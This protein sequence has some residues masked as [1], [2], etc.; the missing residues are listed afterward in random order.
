MLASVTLSPAVRS[1]QRGSLFVPRYCNVQA[2]RGIA[3]LTVVIGH[4][5]SLSLIHVPSWLAVC[6]YSGVDLFFAISGFIIC[7]TLRPP[8]DIN[9]NTLAVRFITKR[10]L[11]IFPLYWISLA[12]VAIFSLW[13][14][15]MPSF[16]ACDQGVFRYISLMTMNNCFIPP[17]WTLQFELYFYT[18][19]AGILVVA[20]RKYYVAI[21]LLMLCQ[22]AIVMVSGSAFDNSRFLSS[23]LILEFGAGCAVAW[24]NQ[25]GFRKAV[26]PVFFIGALVFALG[27]FYALR[28][29]PTPLPRLLTFGF[30]SALIL[31]ALVTL[32]DLHR[33]VLPTPLQRL[34]DAS[35]SLYLWHWPLATLFGKFAFG[36]YGVAAILTLSFISY[37]FIETPLSVVLK[38]PWAFKIGARAATGEAKT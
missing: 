35:Y 13:M 38:Q 20:P 30:G 25:A 26:V 19:F 11:R 18:V 21:G 9:A 27:P 34:G 7:R 6:G 36:W 4:S 16:I 32:E 22:I 28:T 8:E 3:A 24:L 1:K 5:N 14:P 10:Y 23:P 33:F 31:Y 17:A 15:L 37:K 2:L 29:D 12:F